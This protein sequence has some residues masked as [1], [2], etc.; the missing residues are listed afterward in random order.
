MTDVAQGIVRALADD[1]ALGETY[2]FVGPDEFTMRDMLDLM[3]HA[4]KTRTRVLPLPR[5]AM[6][7]LHLAGRIAELSPFRPLLTKDEVTRWGISDTPTDKAGLEALG[8]EAVPLRKVASQFFRRYRGQ[9]YYDDL[10]E[11]IQGR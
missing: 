7:L 10:V 11:D 8:V 9:L 6:P 4:M 2:E 5:Q 1:N 3:T